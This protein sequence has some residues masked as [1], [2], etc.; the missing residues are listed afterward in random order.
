MSEKELEAEAAHY[1][2][3]AKKY[4]KAFTVA[5]GSAIG[6]GALTAFL[7]AAGIA[8]AVSGIGASVGIP[9]GG[10]AAL[11]SVSF[12]GLTAFSKKLQTKL[13]KHEQI[14]TLAISKHNTVCE[15]VS[16]VLN[17]INITD[18][19]FN[20]INTLGTK[21]ILL[22]KSGKRFVARREKSSENKF[23]IYSPPNRN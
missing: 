5:H 10:V 23:R 7:S 22:R 3:V 13:R 9:T 2:H 4:K 17:D 15:L 6:L 12:T 1:R 16:K 18:S 14:Y 11:T 19:K 20:L 21:R 8:T